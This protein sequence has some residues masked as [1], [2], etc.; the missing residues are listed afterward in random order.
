MTNEIK[1]KKKWM[2]NKGVS[3]VVG[4]I[5]LLAIT[6]VLFSS[7]MVFVTNMPTPVNKPSADFVSSMTFLA[8]DHTQGYLNLTH[9][10]GEALW[11]YAT[12]IIVVKEGTITPILFNVTDGGITS[13]KWSI[14]TTWSYLMAGLTTSMELDVK[15]ADTDTNS[16][17]WQ[18]TVSGGTGSS[19]PVIL[20][21]WADADTTTLTVDPIRESD[22]GFT[23]YVRATDPD[24]DLADTGV[25]LDAAA[26]GG[27]SHLDGT[28]SSGVWAFTF[29]GIAEGTA[30]T[31]DGKPLFIHAKDAAN[32][33]TIETFQLEVQQPDITNYEGDTF[34]NY[35]DTTPVEGEGL[36]AYIYYVHGDQGYV[37]V[38]E[39]KT[40]PRTWGA[41]ADTNDYRFNYTQGEGWIFFRVASKV[42]KNVD[43]QNTLSIKNLYSNL[44]VTP[45]S[46]SSAFTLYT[47]SGPVYIYQAKFNSSVLTTGAYAAHLHLESSTMEGIAPGRFQADF[48]LIIDPASGQE[49]V[50]TPSLY[51][52]DKNR[53][54]YSSAQE[55][56]TKTNPFDLSQLSTS[57]VWTEVRMQDVGAASLASIYEV[58]LIDMKG[59]TNLY[60]D[61]PTG[62]GMIS[63][64]S[65]D[66]ANVT[67]YFSIDL[68]L[69]NGM[70]LS[71]G[72][73]AYTIILTK[74][75]DAN[76]G[77]YTVSMPIWV[78]SAVE[79]KNYIAG[80]S[81]F[82][83]G[84]TSGTDNFI[85]SDYMF[86]IENNK[87]FTTAVID[88]ADEDPGGGTALNIL[89]V[90]YFDMDEDGDRDVLAY[91]TRSGSNYL[92]VYINRMNEIGRWEPRSTFTNFTDTGSTVL[93]MAYGDVDGDGDNDWIVS[94][95]SG[96]VYLYVNDF[97]IRTYTVFNTGALKYYT[98][99]RLADVTGDGRADL[100]AM[101][102][103]ASVARGDA[104]SK[105]YM[106]NLSRGTTLVTG[107]APRTPVSIT[108]VPTLD[109][110]VDFDIGDIDEDGDI[111][112]AV[113]SDVNDASHAVRWYQRTETLT[114]PGARTTGEVTTV[115]TLVSGTH[116]DTATDNGGVGYFGYEVIQEVAGDLEHR[117]NLGAITGT[118]PIVYIDA[119]V[120]SGADEGFYFY[121]STAVGGPWTFM[122]LVTSSTT[123]DYTFSFPLPATITGTTYI[124]VVDAASTG[125]SD[126]LI[127]VDRIEI[128]SLASISFATNY[129]V[130]A[131]NA[132]V[133]LFDAIAVGDADGLY[134][135]DIAIGQT[136]STN[137]VYIYKDNAAHSYTAAN[138][139]KINY[140]DYSANG[141]RFFF[142]D[143]NG[144]GL[145]DIVSV[146]EESTS[147]YIAVVVEHLN[148]GTGTTWVTIIVK[149]LYA[150]Y[151]NKG[152]R[153][154]NSI[155]VENMYG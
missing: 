6:V 25:W 112:Y 20:Q 27:S 36:P 83:W 149:D 55:W 84:K 146:A 68:R 79:T 67:Y 111:D 151:G 38:G 88:A 139:Y 17:V 26:I 95:S 90:L 58:R 32:H 57:I 97:P 12:S 76:E 48:I 100:I 74:V 124:R 43:A 129:L 113:L 5:L 29:S 108:N 21:R 114:S 136:A 61:P 93:S 98:E 141:D 13:P 82:G 152:G 19:A 66:N 103:T 15:I 119:K 31:Y 51:L 104:N 1:F 18:G 63:A 148:L 78:R 53:H 59:R 126:D 23:V 94:A 2:D 11:A 107:A 131:N 9:N 121:Y 60:G 33:E 3:E 81:G 37:V 69:K 132:T 54:I 42:V 35:T 28:M 106:W 118:N 144:D 8:S 85:H 143:V 40:A 70:T 147:T 34:N 52:F 116:L 155:A 122:F 86:Q 56:G 135:L 127:Y 24:S 154:I 89:K 150:N 134:Y 123:S 117:W 101:G 87:F 109:N 91:Y 49:S 120:N 47:V 105:M 142:I 45:P 75:F 22:T 130:G 92:G 16:L 99:M 125:S 102:F 41:L 72:L 10:G 64:L 44:E 62:N 145:A 71:P 80:T 46:S 153:E 39:N 110:V 73:A 137:S 96:K 65:T 77:I 140:V 138:C 14:G 133:I 115:G 50:F 4:T 128:I 30:S 7:I